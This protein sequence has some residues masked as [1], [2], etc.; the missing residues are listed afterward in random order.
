VDG[1][2]GSPA[3]QQIDNVGTSPLNPGRYCTRIVIDPAAPDT[4]YATFG[5]YVQGNVWKTTDGGANWSMLGGDTL[6]S[7]PIRAL[8]IHPQSSLMLYLGTEVGLYATEDG[9]TTWSATNEGPDNCSVDDLFWMNRTLVVVTHG[10]GMFSIDLIA[11][12]L[13]ERMRVRAPQ[14]V[15]VGRMRLTDGIVS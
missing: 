1:T 3:W 2:A 11:R 10:R 13:K 7:A 4:V 12:R 5:G 8:A 15:E 9:G 6:P 14:S